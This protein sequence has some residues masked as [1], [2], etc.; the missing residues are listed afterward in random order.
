MCCIRLY[1]I[2]KLQSKKLEF[3]N[4]IQQ[5]YEFCRYYSNA[6]KLTV[7]NISYK[8]LPVFFVKVIEESRKKK[9]ERKSE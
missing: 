6:N 1:S 2:Y 4:R 5:G 3:V 9:M 8:G 7:N